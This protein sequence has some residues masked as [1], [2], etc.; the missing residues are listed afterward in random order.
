V[1]QEAENKEY[2]TYLEQ[3]AKTGEIAKTGAETRNLNLNNPAVQRK[4]QFLAQLQGDAESGKYDPETLKAKYLR[5]AQYNQISVMPEEIDSTIQGTKPLGPKYQIQQ[6]KNGRPEYLTD[7]QGNRLMP[8]A[9]G[10]FADPEAQAQWDAISGAHKQGVEEEV[11]TEGRKANISAN[12][13]ARA[14]SH[15]EDMKAQDQVRP[16]VNTA[17]DADERLSRMEGAYKKAVKGDQQAMLSLLTDHIGMTLGMQKGA[18][19]TKDILNE[20]QTSQPWLAKIASK[21]DGNGY[22][23]GATLGPEQMR[24]MLDLGY[25]ARDR[26]YG[27]ARDAAQTYSVPLPKGFDSVERKRVTG[28]KPA[29]EQPSTQQGGGDVIY[30][31]DPQGK[32]HKAAKGTA[33]PQGWKAENA[34]AGK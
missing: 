19:I 2:N 30:A 29:L 27:S 21:F 16:R 13:Q 22:L 32:L 15:Q 11:A 8:D 4:A 1:K 6:D 14:F 10:K 25:D 23:S 18:R 31:R 26:A 34:P 28:A 17:L 7:R 9:K 24:Q 3:G 33:L 5:M 20:A 12:A